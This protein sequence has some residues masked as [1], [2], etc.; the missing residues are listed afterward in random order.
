M[1]VLLDKLRGILITLFALPTQCL[2]SDSGLPSTTSEKQQ[3]PLEQKRDKVK[4]Y[5]T[6]TKPKLMQSI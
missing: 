3:N 2:C 4:S 5:T 1:L 6:T